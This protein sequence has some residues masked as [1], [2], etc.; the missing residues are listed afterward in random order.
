M[1]PLAGQAG[2]VWWRDWTTQWRNVQ[3]SREAAFDFTEVDHQIDRVVRQKGRVLALFPFP[4]AEWSSEATPEAIDKVVR[5]PWERQR[6]PTAFAPT[7]DA[8]FSQFIFESVKHLGDRCE[9]FQFLNEA[10]YT[11]YALPA[12]AGYK[13]EDY[14]RLLRLAHDALKAARPQAKLLAGL[15]IWADNRYTR[16]FVESGGLQY[17]DALDMHLY[18]AGDPEPYG[19]SIARLWAR[20]KELGV[21]K[22]IWVTELGCYGDDDPPV[23]PFAASFGDDAMRNALK[24]DEREAAEWLVKF[25]VMVFASGGEKIFL[26]AGTC[27]EINGDSTGGV[28]FKYGGVPRKILPAV[29]TLARL[30]PPS[31]R[32][33]RTEALGDG[34]LAYQFRVGEGT[35]CVAWVPEGDAR[36]LQ[37]PAGRKALDIMGNPLA[38]PTHIDGTPIYLVG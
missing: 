7:D 20:M 15:G 4:S 38:D 25:S 26:H 2:I 28:F 6:V 17:A 24:A 35:V 3:R 16:D 10:L 1:L 34:I 14:V 18:P 12:A 22:P 13:L 19:E 29:S 5:K 33:E 11:T 31:A 27:G 32:F 23:T 30:L 21:A 37:V 36:P 9:W 8:A